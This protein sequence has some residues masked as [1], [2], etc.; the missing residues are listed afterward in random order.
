MVT[1]N[2]RMSP[3]GNV[4]KKCCF[5]QQMFWNILNFTFIL[6]FHSTYSLSM[7]CLIII[8]QYYFKLL[9]KVLLDPIF[10]LTENIFLTHF[11]SYLK[12]MTFWLLNYNLGHVMFW[13]AGTA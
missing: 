6:E 5:S 3:R 10:I 4:I 12:V 11:G 2:S 1:I 8:S 7:L 9:E 13:L